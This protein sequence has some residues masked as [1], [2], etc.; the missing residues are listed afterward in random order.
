MKKKITNKTKEMVEN[1]W[2][3]NRGI[4]DITIERKNVIDKDMVISLC[5]YFYKKA[6]LHGIKHGL[7]G[8]INENTK[9]S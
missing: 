9:K 8:R 7:E 4:I 6:M 2:K 1:H 5:G 3:Y